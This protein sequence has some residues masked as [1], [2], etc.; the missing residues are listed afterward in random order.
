MFNKVISTLLPGAFAIALALSPVV[1]A[2][3]AGTDD[4]ADRSFLFFGKKKKKGKEAETDS[5][6]SKNS[7]EKI[8]EGATVSSDGLFKVVS[9]KGDY[10][11]EIP[12]KLMGKDM[13]VVNKFVKVPSELNDAGVN[14]GINYSNRMVSFELDTVAKRVMVRQSRPLPDVKPEDALSRS[15]ADNY[16]SPIMASFN[17]EA[18][19]TDSTAVVV[20]VN[21]IYDG[22]KTSFN[23]VFNEIN[24]GG[25]ADKSLSKIKS[26]KA[27]DNNIYA[28]SELTTAVSEPGGKVYVTVEVGSTLLLLPEKPMARRYVC[29]RVGYFTESSLRYSDKQQRVSRGHYITR[30]RLVPR[31]EDKA[32]YL[33]GKLVE[34]EKSIVFWLDNTV[35]YQWRPYIKKGIEDWNAAFEYAGFKNAVRVNQIPDSTD[36]DMDDM[37]YSTL[38]YAASRQSNAMGPSITDPRSGEILEAD[39]IWW[40]NVLDLLHDWIVIQTGAVDPRARSLELPEELLGDAMRFVACH[41]V[42]HSLGLRHNM[43][44]SAAIPTDS[45]RS[46]KYVEEL[47]GTS[48][49]IMDYARFNYV[50]QPGDGVKTLSPHIGPYDRLAIEYGY[51]WFGDEGPESE[52]ELLQ[53]LLDSHEGP[54]FAYSEAQDSREAI[55]P[56]A[57][58]E[59]LGDDP[60]KSAKYGMDNLR[61]IMPKIIEWTTEGKPGQDYD[62][63]SRLYY[64]VVG[65][66]QRYLYHVLANV[67][68]IYVDNTTIGDGRHTYRFVDTDRQRQAVQFLIDEAFTQPSW[69]FDADVTNYTFL[70]S[71]TPIG[72]VENSPNYI[73][74]NAQSFLLWDLLSDNRIIRMYENEAMNKNKAFKG[75]DMMDMLHNAI[76]AKTIKIGRAHV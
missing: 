76:F 5:V 71:N 15:V 62:E 67:G 7:Y 59:D 40:H 41:E 72:R 23:D 48:S 11:F 3:A 8:T 21:D 24:I 36:I 60:V 42:G 31:E 58:N 22:T 30:W 74:K 9:K 54:M 10:Y 66:W 64:S 75:S 39:I 29:P 18:Y 55:D 69:L 28:V 44:A 19:N 52:D 2:A 33:A 20:K 14:R 46:A 57:L 1:P 73:L 47:G 68:G 17:I 38:T 34:P 27:F 12:K 56:R 37:S 61:R 49:S 26:I 43:M 6:K 16:I 65:Q 53:K 50:A 35:P 13:L 25:S 63:A 51:R 4:A 70:V 32:D 45:L